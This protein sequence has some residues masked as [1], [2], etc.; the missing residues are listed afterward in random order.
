MHSIMEHVASNMALL[1]NG[2]TQL[3][4]AFS[5]QGRPRVLPFSEC[6]VLIYINLDKGMDV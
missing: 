5:D 2:H 1:G 4:F 3:M 6:I